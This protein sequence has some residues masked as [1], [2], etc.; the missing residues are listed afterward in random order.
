MQISIKEKSTGR[1]MFTEQVT[2]NI[3]KFT[4]ETVHKWKNKLAF[5]RSDL[6]RLQ[7]DIT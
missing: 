5:T 2:T 3:L 4:Y 7:Y 6:L 1:E